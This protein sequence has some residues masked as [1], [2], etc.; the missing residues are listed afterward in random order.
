[1]SSTLSCPSCQRT[2]RV[3][4]S[5]LGK[6]VKCPGCSHRFTAADQSESEEE[7]PRRSTAVSEKPSRRPAAPPPEDEEV[8]DRR[9]S[10]RATR[11]DEDDDR[12]I[13]RSRRDEEEDDDEERSPS[14]RDVKAAW[15]KVRIGINVVMIGTWI[16]VGGA[17][18]GGLGVLLVSL[19]AA[20][21]MLLNLLK[22]LLV[23]SQGL[24]FLS[25][26]VEWILRM[27]GYGL[28]M[29]VPPQRDTGL[30]PLSITAFGLLASATLFLFLM[31]VM[32]VFSSVSL[33]L[34][35]RGGGSIAGILLMG[36]SGLFTIASF[37]VY[38]FFLRSVCNNVRARHLAGQPVTILIAFISFW[39]GSVILMV[40]LMAIAQSTGPTFG[41]MMQSPDG[42]QRANRSLRTWN[43]INNIALGILGLGYLGLNVWY[44]KVLQSI[45][46]TVDSYRSRLKANSLK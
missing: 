41:E 22:I 36:T 43:V 38:L 20:G 5:L 40:L 39:I 25:L 26:F 29:L 21:G 13:Q 17:A 10:R 27:V 46:D 8:E 19:L 9:P 18:V 16:W 28:C 24:F 31:L 30:R 35:A 11:D 33:S 23:L 45:R 3:P 14:P 15:N 37:I 32:A 7:A 6:N 2:L 4:E 12:R 44:L 1:M 42:F 34:G